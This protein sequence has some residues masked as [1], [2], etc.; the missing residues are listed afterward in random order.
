MTVEDL[1][2]GINE[3]EDIHD[4]SILAAQYAVNAQIESGYPICEDSIDVHLSLLQEWE[5][6]FDFIL[7][8]IEA[9]K[10]AN[11]TVGE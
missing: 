4:R 2:H 7:A 10:L 6:D 11:K 1:V 8:S 5:C 9:E 3:H